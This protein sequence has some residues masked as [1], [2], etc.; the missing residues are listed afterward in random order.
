MLVYGVTLA[1]IVEA[2]FWVTVF[3]FDITLTTQMIIFMVVLG[4]TAF[5]WGAWAEVAM[6]ARAK[7]ASGDEALRSGYSGSHGRATDGDRPSALD[8]ERALREIREAARELGVAPVEYLAWCRLRDWRMG[9]EFESLKAMRA[10][11]TRMH[12]SEVRYLSEHTGAI[13]G[14]GA[15]ESIESVRLSLRY[16]QAILGDH[17]LM[18]LLF[19]KERQL[20]EHL[21]IKVPYIDPQA[22]TDPPTSLH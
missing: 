1:L 8:E 15:S 22:K 3:Y 4:I 21:R 19:D 14:A 13:A 2:G 11:L 5:C 7:R 6:H 17:L 10:A 18:G 9:I 20:L 12:K 16:F